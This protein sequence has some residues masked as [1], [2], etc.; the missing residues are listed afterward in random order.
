MTRAQ[1]RKLLHFPRHVFLDTAQLF[2]FAYLRTL[3][4]DLPY[5]GRATIMTKITSSRR[6]DM[7]TRTLLLWTITMM[8][9]LCL[10]GMADAG[11]VTTINLLVD[12][13][14]SSQSGEEQQNS[15]PSI[16]VNPNNQNQMIVGA[17]TS[18]FSPAPI[19]STTPFFISNNGGTIWADFGSLQTLDKSIAF[20]GSTPLATTL[21]GIADG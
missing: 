16:A 15:E 13:I 17:F 9:W 14:P 10:A 1:R 3:A 20:N 5:S 11:P 8:S 6:A 18:I 7:R 12:V 21:N 19:N 4:R 2:D